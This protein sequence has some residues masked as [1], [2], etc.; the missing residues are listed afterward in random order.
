MA[1]PATVAWPHLVPLASPSFRRR[2][3]SGCP[4]TSTD[5]SPLGPRGHVHGPNR[6]PRHPQV[7]SHPHLVSERHDHSVPACDLTEHPRTGGKRCAE[8]NP[9]PTG[10]SLRGQLRGMVL[11][12]GAAKIGRSPTLKAAGRFD[13]SSSARTSAQRQQTT[14]EPEGLGSRTGE[15]AGPT[16][17]ATV[18][19]AGKSLG[20]PGGTPPELRC[21]GSAKWD[22][23]GTSRVVVVVVIFF[24]LQPTACGC[25]YLPISFTFP[26]MESRR[27]PSL[28]HKPEIS[29]GSGGTF[30]GHRGDR[31][32]T[33]AVRVWVTEG[34][35]GEEQ[36]TKVGKWGNPGCA[37]PATGEEGGK[38]DHAFPLAVSSAQAHGTDGARSAQ[39]GHAEANANDR[40]DGVPSQEE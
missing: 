1:A 16:E 38:V 29:R 14:G 30:V 35:K 19:V 12:N 7:P 22:T 4:S 15:P 6:L 21:S 39:R 33:C 26:L 28:T 11:T 18:A 25:C 10:H 36:G 8:Q 40:R 23:G 20:E 2:D 31:G 13:P 27:C 37:C 32:G 24:D 9:L 5:R 3:Q 34:T 17:P